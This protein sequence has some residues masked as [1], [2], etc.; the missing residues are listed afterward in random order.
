LR[1]KS[2]IEALP[3]CWRNATDHLAGPREEGKGFARRG[4]VAGDRQGIEVDKGQ[5]TIWCRDENAAVA[6]L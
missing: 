5:C 6:N 2:E 3:E 1:T 4:L